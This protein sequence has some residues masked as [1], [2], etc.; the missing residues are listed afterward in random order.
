METLA[1]FTFVVAIAAIVAFIGGVGDSMAIRFG[2]KMTR[3]KKWIWNIAE[4]LIV[5]G[6]LIAIG[7]EDGFHWFHIV[8]ACANSWFVWR[9][10]H[11]GVIGWMIADDFFYLGSGAWDS[12]ML[13]T[14]QNNRYLYFALNKCFPWALLILWFFNY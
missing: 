9:I 13:A 5:F 11:D 1:Y 2:Q 7:I 14:Y 6:C 10:V 4:M 8:I 12:K 3:V